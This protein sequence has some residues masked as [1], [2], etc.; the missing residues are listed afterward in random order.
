MEKK[1]EKI[2]TI[3]FVNPNNANNSI[4]VTF[5][6]KEIYLVKGIADCLSTVWRNIDYLKWIQY[7]SACIQREYKSINRDRSKEKKKLTDNPY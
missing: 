4:E 3:T 1:T 5:R 6:N 2:K 7:V